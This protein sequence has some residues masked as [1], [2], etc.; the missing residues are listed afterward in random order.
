MILKDIIAHLEQIAPLEY[1]ASYDNSGLIVG[2]ETLKVTAAVVSLDC[3]EDVVEEAIS[4]GANLIIAHHP[5][6]FSGLKKFNGSNYVE[7]TVIKAIENKVAIYAIHTNLDSVSNGVNKK[8]GDLLA[9]QNLQIL[10][11]NPGMDNVG[12][13]MVGEVQNHMEETAFLQHVKKALNVPMLK[14]T[15]LLNKHVK[16]VAFCG[17]SGS[18]LLAD[19]IAQGADVFITSD[20]KYHQYFDAENQIVIVDIGHYEAESCT[21]DLICEILTEKFPTFTLHFSEVNTN[22]VKYL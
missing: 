6:V 8:I 16:K 13:G 18:F 1:Q 19:A 22:P 15:A 7:R 17:G 14:Y 2:N 10:S 5:I 3:T 20:F 11:V 21:K 9:L 4:K 12:A